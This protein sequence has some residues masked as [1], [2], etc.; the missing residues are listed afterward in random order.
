MPAIFRT[1][2]AALLPLVLVAALVAVMVA[3][4]P[5]ANASTRSQK[6]GVGLDVVRHQKGDPYRYGAAGPRAFD[7]SGLIYYSFRKAGFTHI[8][9]SSDAQAHHMNRLKRSHMRRGDFVFFYQGRAA[10][11]NVYHVGVFAGWKKGHRTIIHAPSGNQR[12]RRERIWTHHWFPG[13]L[14]GA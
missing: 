5:A 12:V 7:C 14:R 3:L 2:S 1:R 13:S 4:A 8:P 9:R 10:A 11:H 6:I